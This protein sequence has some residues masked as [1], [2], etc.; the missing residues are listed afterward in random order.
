MCVDLEDHKQKLEEYKIS[1]VGSQTTLSTIQF[2]KILYQVL[3]NKEEIV[4]YLIG[5]N[6][7]TI[8]R[9]M[10]LAKSLGSGKHFDNISQDILKLMQDSLNIK[11]DGSGPVVRIR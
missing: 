4:R 9:G 2:F 3:D 8:I 5:N 11:I 6:L 10:D 1:L 7:I